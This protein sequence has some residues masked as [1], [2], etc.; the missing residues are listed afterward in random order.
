MFRYY[1]HGPDEVE[2]LRLLSVLGEGPAQLETVVILQANE[3]SKYF[4]DEEGEVHFSRCAPDKTADLRVL[5][6]DF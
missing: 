5:Q 3:A 4:P 1:N 2:I 6:M